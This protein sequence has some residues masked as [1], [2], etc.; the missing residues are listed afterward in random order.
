MDNQDYILSVFELLKKKIFTFYSNIVN[1]MNE[2]SVC[3][4]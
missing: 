1:L 4:S 2:D 3:R